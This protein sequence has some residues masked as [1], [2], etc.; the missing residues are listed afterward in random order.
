MFIHRNGAQGIIGE[1]GI[2]KDGFAFGCLNG[3]TRVTEPG[4]FVFCHLFLLFLQQ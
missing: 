2:D 1:P 3:K 4:Y